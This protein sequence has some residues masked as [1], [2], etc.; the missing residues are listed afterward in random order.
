MSDPTNEMPSL[1]LEESLRLHAIDA[2]VFAPFVIARIR[3]VPEDTEAILQVR[4][5]EESASEER[6]LHVRLQ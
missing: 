2:S 4:M 1:H 3:A 5:K 6:S